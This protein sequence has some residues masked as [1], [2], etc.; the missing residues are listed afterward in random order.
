LALA[1]WFLAAILDYKVALPG[2][3][4]QFPRDHFSHPEYRTEWWYYTGNVH[5][6][7]GHRYG[8]ELVFFRQ[9]KDHKPSDNPTAW[10]L[11][12][13]YLAHLALTDIDGGHFRYCKRLNRPGPGIAGVSFDEGRI[14]NG[15]WQV[16]WDKATN[17]QSLTAVAE[18][19]NFSLRL[20]PGKPPVINGENGVSQKAAGAGRASY[21]VSFPRL[22]VDGKLNG[23]DVTGTA[24]MDHEWFTQQL[25]ASQRGWDWFSVQLENGADLMLFDLRHSDGT[26]EPYSSGTFIAKDGRATH[27][28]RADFELLPLEYWTSPKTGAKYPVKWRIAVPSKGVAL[29]CTAAVRAQELVDEEDAGLTYWEGAVTYSGSSAGVGYLEMTGYAAPVKL[30]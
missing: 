24:W 11:D 25:D 7:D 29:E 14:W 13:L 10:R 15:N 19:V 4:Y 16:R 17:V 5:A 23:A 6:S 1:L 27:L 21:Y 20:T 26:V 30:Y 12:D 2:Y 22:A 9:G 8:F 18:G 3:R 28:K